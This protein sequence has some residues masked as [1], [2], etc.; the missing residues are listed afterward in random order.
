MRKFILFLVISSAFLNLPV[1][2]SERQLELSNEELYQLKKPLLSDY[3][4]RIPRNPNVYDKVNTYSDKELSKVSGQ[5]VPNQSIKITA[6]RVNDQG[7][8]I[9]ELSNKTYILASQSAIF[10]DLP[11]EHSYQ[12]S[13]SWT[14]PGFRVYSSVLGSEAK[15]IKANLSAYSKVQISETVATPRGQFAKI[16]EGWVNLKDL[17]Q[18]DN[19]V[20]KVQAM[21]KEKYNKANYS[22][23]VH[24]LDTG[25]TAGINQDKTMYSASI[26]KLPILYYTQM[27]LDKGK[28]SLS[29]T[30]QYTEEVNRFTGS[31]KTGGSGSMSKT[32]D[33]KDYRL[34][35]LIDATA[36]QSDNAASNILSYYL[37]H[38]FDDDYYQ[39]MDGLVSQR[40]DMTSRNSTAKMAGQVMVALYR[41]N[42]SSQVLTSLS[43]TSFDSERIAKNID[44]KI[45]HKIGDAYDYRHDV[46]LV[47]ADSPFVISIF[48]EHSS[49]DKISDI[50]DDVYAILK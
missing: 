26:A 50:A 8:P 44:T 24:Q 36:K 7:E 4:D 13:H 25:Q 40:W 17:S 46:A 23:Y 33:N 14:K 45:A 15:E 28:V 21:L 10:E 5:L 39:T 37:T 18:T 42:P 43:E 35:Q 31:Y 32:A 47:Y 48:T 38:R 20:E 1:V 16:K 3:Y 41:Q 22:V 2:S 6:F 49:Y 34:D 30:F 9:F 27:Q 11:L 19:R 29:D 12:Q